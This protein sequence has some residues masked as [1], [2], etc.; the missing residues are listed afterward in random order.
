MI[1][2]L[3]VVYTQKRDESMYF[4]R[5]RSTTAPNHN[6]ILVDFMP[7]HHFI[8]WKKS[9]KSMYLRGTFSFARQ[10]ITAPRQNKFLPSLIHCHFKVNF[11]AIKPCFVLIL[12]L[13]VS[14]WPL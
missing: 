13:R 4:L 8:D 14:R 7:L 10:P 3:H 6:I 1:T 12:T 9:W 11:V 5:V 2:K